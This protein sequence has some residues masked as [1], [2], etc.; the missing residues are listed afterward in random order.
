MQGYKKMEI[1]QLTSVKRSMQIKAVMCSVS[2][3]DF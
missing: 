1:N 3:I 2:F